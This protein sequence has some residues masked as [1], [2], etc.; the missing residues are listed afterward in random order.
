MKCARCGRPASRTLGIEVRSVEGEIEEVPL[1]DYCFYHYDARRGRDG[2]LIFLRK[3]VFGR[4]FKILLSIESIRLVKVLEGLA[5]T[6]LGAIAASRFTVAVSLAAMALSFFLMLQTLFNYIINPAFLAMARKIYAEHPMYGLTMIPGIDPLVPILQGWIALI[7]TISIHE[8]F[9]ALS[10]ARLGT[11]EPRAVGLLLFGPIPVGGYVD[12]NPIFLKRPHSSRV[13]SAGVFS[14][15]LL[16]LLCW[17]GLIIHMA[18]RFQIIDFRLLLFPPEM[19]SLLG[20]RVMVSDLVT[21][22]LSWVGFFN[23]WVALLNAL[24]I[25]G[26]DGYY[27]LAEALSPRIGI[28]GGFRVARV[29]GFLA[30]GLLLGLALLNRMPWGWC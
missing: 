28:A 8:T 10:A 5:E 30:V 23:L 22:L 24:P 1:C 11:G 19:I 13:S 3:K 20:G 18:V 4:K 12:V 7:L 26:L 17:I 25:P 14:N 21:S 27:T 16:A 6:P 2:G 29:I 15:I 9:H